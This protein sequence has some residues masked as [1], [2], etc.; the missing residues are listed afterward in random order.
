[1]RQS[2]Q[3][4]FDESEIPAPIDG[5]YPAF[6]KA[7]RDLDEIEYSTATSITTERHFA[8]NWVC[9]YSDDW[10]KTPTDT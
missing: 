10:D 1:M 6:G 9:G 7:Y 8:L 4:P 3:L 5:D 2:A